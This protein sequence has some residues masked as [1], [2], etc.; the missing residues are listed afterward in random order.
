[1][2]SKQKILLWAQPNISIISHRCLQ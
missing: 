1:M 2:R